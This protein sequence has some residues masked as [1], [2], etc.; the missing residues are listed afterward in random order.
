VAIGTTRARFGRLRIM[1]GSAALT[2][3]L[4]VTIR[5]EY[6]NGGFVLNSLDNCTTLSQA[7]LV[8]GAYAKSLAACETRAYNGTVAAAPQTISFTGGRGTL[9]LAA[10][11]AGNTG[12]VVLTANLGT[13]APL[14][15]YC[16]T[17]GG[18]EV[19]DAAASRGYLQG[20]WGGAPYDKNPAAR[21]SFGTYGTQPNNLI[22]MRENY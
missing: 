9:Y 21:F 22:F 15:K 12:S 20:A 1:P 13:T 7:N 3:N 11:G 19:D 4:P 6:Y 5:T 18:A 10:P 16:Q 8:L 17:V 2:I 14:G